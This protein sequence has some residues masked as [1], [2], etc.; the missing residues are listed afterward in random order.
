MLSVAMKLVIDTVSVRSNC[1][2]GERRYGRRRCINSVMVLALLLAD[3]FPAASFAQAYRV[4]LPAVV[5]V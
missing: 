4:L 1:R 5:K 2:N 3:T